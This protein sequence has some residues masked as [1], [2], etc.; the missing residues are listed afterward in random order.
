MEKV[1]HVVASLH[2]V[3]KLCAI[4]LR[5]VRVI[6]V[7]LALLFNEEL[8]KPGANDLAVGELPPELDLYA[9][10]EGA[11]SL[12]PVEGEELVEVPPVILTRV[13]HLYAMLEGEHTVLLKEHKPQLLKDAQ[14][15]LELN[16]ELKRRC[17]PIDIGHP[18][19]QRLLRRWDLGDVPR[20]QA[21]DSGAHGVRVE[22]RLNLLDLEIKELSHQGQRAKEEE[23]LPLLALV[24]D[25]RLH[26]RNR[27]SRSS[28]LHQLHQRAVASPARRRLTIGRHD[29][30]VAWLLACCLVE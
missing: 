28:H 9:L 29:L 12:G 17:P 7:L 2:G 22:C 1:D 11:L 10:K 24:L 30:A 6:E 8:I 14:E 25:Q 15:A 16:E 3:R 18:G 19:E 13:L 20:C 4:T 23:V 27:I 26:E 5:S 21:T